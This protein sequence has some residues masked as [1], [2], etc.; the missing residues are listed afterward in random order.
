MLK[1]LGA[2]GVKKLA[3]ASTIRALA[4]N[5]TLWAAGEKPRALCLVTQGMLHLVKISARGK[6]T[7]LELL[8]PGDAVGCIAI[9]TDTALIADV[10]AV[11][12]ST[13]V[14]IPGHLACKI[15][16][17]DPR[18]L[19]AVAIQLA[20]RL[21]RQTLFRSLSSNPAKDRIA[22][23]LGYIYKNEARRE[24]ALTQAAVARLT[25]LSEATV[26]RALSR[27]KK[28]GI[29]SISRGTISVVNPALL[30]KLSDDS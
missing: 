19:K 10:A 22:A 28:R 26:N 3:A 29:V 20:T 30:M 5:E 18:W 6:Q 23:L 27:L 16:G 24:L 17:N 1:T 7:S 12:K 14:V 25:D 15:G 2:S 13:V 4:A 11:V 8:H 9:L 21:E